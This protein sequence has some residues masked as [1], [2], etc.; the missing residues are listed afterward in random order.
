MWKDT[1]EIMLGITNAQSNV[2][3]RSHFLKAGRGVTHKYVEGLRQEQH[4]PGGKPGLQVP[5]EPEL[6]VSWGG[7]IHQ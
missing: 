1:Q 6:C 7:G 5:E 2:S 4:D 3:A